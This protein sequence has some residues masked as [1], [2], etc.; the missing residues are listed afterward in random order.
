MGYPPALTSYPLCEQESSSESPEVVVQ[1]APEEMMSTMS[2]LPPAGRHSHHPCHG[3]QIEKP[4]VKGE[5][6]TSSL[7]EEPSD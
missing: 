2:D 1:A 4:Q 6:W 5:K 3:G 7:E